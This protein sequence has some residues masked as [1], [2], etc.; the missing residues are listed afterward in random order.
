MHTLKAVITTTHTKVLNLVK[1]LSFLS[2]LTMFAFAIS[3]LPVLFIGSFSYFTSSKEI[4]KMLTKAKWNL[5][6]K[7]PQM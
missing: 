6:Y 2:K 5:F 1:S 4:Q 3:I 7:L